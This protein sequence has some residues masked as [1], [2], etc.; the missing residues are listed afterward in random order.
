MDS[1]HA[2]VSHFHL[3]NFSSPYNDKCWMTVDPETDRFQ[4]LSNDTSFAYSG[5]DSIV[6]GLGAA[7]ESTVGTVFN[8][9]VILAILNDAKIRK[10]YMSPAIISLAA[11]DFLFSLLTLPV[12][13]LLF[14][15]KYV[16]INIYR[17]VITS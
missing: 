17:Y 3:V 14:F 11:T 12:L 1:N 4:F 5:A 15:K 13:S 8:L 10:E 16:Y 9:L 6:A 2:N 7:F